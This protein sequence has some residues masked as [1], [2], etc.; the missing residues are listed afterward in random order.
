[1]S[2]VRECNF[3]SIPSTYLARDYKTVYYISKKSSVEV[4]PARSSDVI[5]KYRSETLY[6]TNDWKD[7]PDGDS[8]TTGQED[9]LA[10]SGEGRSNILERLD[11]RLSERIKKVQRKWADQGY[12]ETAGELG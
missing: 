6:V 5:D 3:Q 10:E 2:L 8:Y 7:N 9:G 12:G 1:V 4:V 11:N